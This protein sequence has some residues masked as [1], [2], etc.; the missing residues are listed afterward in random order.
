MNA[1]GGYFIIQNLVGGINLGFSS[2]NVGDFSVSSF[3]VG[4]FARY[5]FDK[6]FFGASFLSVNS[7]TENVGGDNN[8]NGTQFNLEL[9]YAAFLNN[10][11]AIEPA[12]TYLTTGGDLGGVTG[13]SLNIGFN[14]YL[15]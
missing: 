13:F 3:N 4:P 10:S 15:K 1:R 6:A 5:Y 2:T 9:G 11:V 7:K 12:L 8:T 14:I